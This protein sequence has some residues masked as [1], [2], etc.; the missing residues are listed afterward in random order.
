MLLCLQRPKEKC[1][2]EA[3]IGNRRAPTRR[4]AVGDSAS[5]QDQSIEYGADTIDQFPVVGR[6]HPVVLSRGILVTPDEQT[7]L[8]RRAFRQIHDSDPTVY[9]DGAPSVRIGV[10]V[11]A[12]AELLFAEVLYVKATVPPTTAFLRRTAGNQNATYLRRDVAWQP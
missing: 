5:M 8:Q 10:T 1:L 11:N 9:S 6:R 3:P 7:R 12:L 2:K 4:A